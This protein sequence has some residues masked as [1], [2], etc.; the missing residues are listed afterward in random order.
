M[1]PTTKLK[2]KFFKIDYVLCQFAYPEEHGYI[3]FVQ[4]PHH[5]R[6]QYNLKNL[7]VENLELVRTELGDLSK[8]FDTL[9]R[10]LGVMDSI[11]PKTDKSYSTET[12]LKSV[13][14]TDLIGHGIIIKSKT[15]PLTAGIVSRTGK[16]IEIY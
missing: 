10:S 6:A 15:G 4:Y 9:G 3:L 12:N 1:N 2:Y 16:K 13:K 5:V 14:I 7:P 11:K 8:G